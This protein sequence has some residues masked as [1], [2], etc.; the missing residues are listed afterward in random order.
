MRACAGRM[1]A[2]EECSPARF[3]PRLLP[4]KRTGTFGTVSARQPGI[5]FLEAEQS[6]AIVCSRLRF[7]G[8]VSYWLRVATL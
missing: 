6:G 8:V 4:P 5:A 2:A 3:R 1:A 7:P